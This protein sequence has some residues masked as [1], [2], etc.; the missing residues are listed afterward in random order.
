MADD[1]LKTGSESPGPDRSDD[2]PVEDAPPLQEFQAQET[3]AP[4]KEQGPAELGMGPVSQP[5]QSVIPEMGADDPAHFAPG[6][7]VVDFDKINELIV[8]GQLLCSG[9]LP[10]LR[11]HFPDGLGLSRQTVICLDLPDQIHALLV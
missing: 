4:E 9:L 6:E 2:V 11:Q 1:K 10:C 3:S 7:V 5:D 8:T